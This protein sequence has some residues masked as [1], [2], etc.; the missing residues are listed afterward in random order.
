MPKAKVL[1][2]TVSEG[3]P[4][5][6]TIYSK[7]NGLG[8]TD[9]TA[10]MVTEAMGVAQDDMVHKAELDTAALDQAYAQARKLLEGYVN[11]LGNLLGIDYNVEFKEVE[12]DS[13]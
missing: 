7:K 3:T 10:E 9:V 11:N 13:K 2:A 1:R 8:A 6:D 12:E 4:N 5:R